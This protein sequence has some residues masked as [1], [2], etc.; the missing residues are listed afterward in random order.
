ML[1]GTWGVGD[2]RKKNSKSKKGWKPDRRL[3]E[4]NGLLHEEWEIDDGV[5]LR[6][7]NSLGL[8]IEQI[9]PSASAGF[10]KG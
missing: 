8:S 2:Q 9:T 7:C 1:L 3:E 4:F 10:P 6:V 5:T